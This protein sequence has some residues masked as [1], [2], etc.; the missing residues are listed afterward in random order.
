MNKERKKQ[1]KINDNLCRDICRKRDK[2]CVYCFRSHREINM[3]W[4]HYITRSNHHVRW[5]LDNTMMM[6]RGCHSSFAHQYH[7]RFTLWMQ[8]KLKQRYWLLIKASNDTS[9]LDLKAIEFCL[10]QKLNEYE[11]TS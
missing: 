5:N 6:H 2:F 1:I 11:R 7:H 3:D 4:V 8:Q 9:K 10:R